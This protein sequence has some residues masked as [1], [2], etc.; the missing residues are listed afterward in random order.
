MNAIEIQ[1]RRYLDM[2]WVPIALG[3]DTEGRPKKP[4]AEKWETLTVNDPRVRQQGWKN[5]IGIG[6]AC[7][8]QSNNLA[9]IDIDDQSLALEVFFKLQRS[10]Q[11]FRWVWSIRKRGHLYLYEREPSKVGE[12]RR[13]YTCMWQ[14][15]EVKV[16]VRTE[17]AQVAAPGTP[18]YI[19]ARDV[20]PQTVQDATSAFS[21][22][23]LAVGMEPKDGDSGRDYPEP[24]QDMVGEGYRNDALFIEACKLASV[25]MQEDRAVELLTANIG[26]HYSG[27]ISPIE[28]KR[29]VRSAYRRAWPKIAGPAENERYRRESW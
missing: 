5:A 28:I 27:H 13:N 14:G 23:C 3:A 29:T 21:A 9:V 25:R 26:S 7:G 4:L 12:T 19:L 8:P 15:K 6:V 22:I 10:K 2:G 11:D 1:A 18:G 20:P 17:G 24:W 16:E